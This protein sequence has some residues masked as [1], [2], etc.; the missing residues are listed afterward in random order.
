MS[1]NFVE[2]IE[3]FPQNPRPRRPSSYLILSVKDSGGELTR[4]G[5]KTVSSPSSLALSWQSF[6]LI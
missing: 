1:H 5:A 6:A 3:I 2:H 4:K